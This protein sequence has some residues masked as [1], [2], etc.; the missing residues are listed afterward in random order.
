MSIFDLPFMRRPLLR[1]LLLCAGLTTLGAQASEGCAAH[2]P[3]GTVPTITN[4]RMMVATDLLC[5]RQ[6]AVLHSGLT[7]TA[8]YSAERMSRQ[9]VTKA[10]EQIRVNDFHAEPRLKAAE[11]AELSDYVRSGFDRGHLTP[12]GNAQDARSQ[13]ETFTLANIVPQDPDHNRNLWADIE[14]AVRNEAVRRGELY[15]ITGPLFE[16]ETL[17]QIGRRVMVPTSLFKLVYDPQR[18]QAAAYV[19]RNR[20]GRNYEVISVAELERRAGI[21]LLPT[22]SREQKREVLKLPVPQPRQDRRTDGGTD[23]ALTPLIN[24]VARIAR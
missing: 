10:R 15:V 24:F 11:R 19:S 18:R 13:Q 2:F 5:Y 17:R 1:G 12:S 8:L 9:T 7:R 6:F 3:A 14:I 23:V 22:L 4:S 16:G 21:N 20:P